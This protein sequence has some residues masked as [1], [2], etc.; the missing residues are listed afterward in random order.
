MV[1]GPT[2]DTFDGT[3]VTGG[4]TLYQIEFR[5]ETIER[6]YTETRVHWKW[7]DPNKGVTNATSVTC[8]L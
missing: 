1:K 7:R 2:R 6:L 8:M 4:D 3:N 5:N